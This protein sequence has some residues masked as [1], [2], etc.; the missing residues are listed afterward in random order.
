MNIAL[1]TDAFPPMVD[2]VSRC[3]LGYAMGMHE[4]RF[5][6]CLVVAPKQPR[7]DYSAYPFPI[8]GFS[9]FGLWYHDYRAGHPYMPKL[10]KRMREMKI[11][12]IHSH[13]PFTAMSIS[14]QLRRSLKV[15]VVFTQ[16]TKWDYDLARAMPVRPIAWILERYVYNNIKAANEVWAVSD[17][18]G[19]YLNE[20]GYK[21]DYFVMPNGTDFPSGLADESKLNEVSEKHS[22]PADVPVLLFVGRMMMY[23]GISLIIEALEMLCAKKFDFRMIFVGDG[24]DLTAAKS[25]VKGKNLDDYVHFTGRINDRETIRTYYSRADLFL[26]P[27]TYDNAPLVVQE[28]AACETPSIV[29]RGSSSAEV[30][31]EGVNGY[32][33]EQT[34]Q[35]LAETIL[36]VF[37]DKA[38]HKEVSK[39]ALEQVYT[40]WTKVVERSMERYSVVK[41]AFDKSMK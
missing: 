22:L 20:R 34:S 25:M 28:A 16:H 27:S 29:I 38:K 18:T 31:E 19:K 5:G 2:G 41:E 3:A 36:E 33:S 14:R 7:V 4:G 35:S 37:H 23:K 15:P 24:N 17:G 39:A 10:I 30:I 26:L 9:S 12:L 1:I 40:P 32:M 6:D 8:Y 11:D 21:G 13:S